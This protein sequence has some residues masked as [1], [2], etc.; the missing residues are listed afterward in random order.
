[1]PPSAGESQRSGMKVSGSAKL[2]AERTVEYMD[3]ETD[4][5]GLSSHVS[6]GLG[7]GIGG[8]GTYTLRHIL[9]VNHRSSLRDK[10]R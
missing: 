8:P 9:T 5:Y 1:M 6:I 7:V 2:V 4:V 3:I 10:T